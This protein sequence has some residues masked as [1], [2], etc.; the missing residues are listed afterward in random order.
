MPVRRR[1]SLA[2]LVAAICVVGLSGCERTLPVPASYRIVD[3][4]VQIAVCTAMDA[5][6]IGV[7]AR[8]G[9]LNSREWTK[10]WEA[11]GAAEFT[12]GDVF[13][14]QHPP[15]GMTTTV[16][17]EAQLAAGASLIISAS[18]IAREDG[19]ITGE[20]PVT[21]A[22]LRGDGWTFW[23]GKHDSDPCNVRGGVRG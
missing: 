21:E 20:F 9:V 10:V 13:D 22:A 5:R 1:W 3:G 11:R 12:R 17:T 14:A 7:Q 18:G 19:Y 4:H 23:N 2:V 8:G 16:D 6:R 15:A